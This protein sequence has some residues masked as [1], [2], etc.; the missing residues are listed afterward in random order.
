[1]GSLPVVVLPVTG[2][3][4]RARVRR[5]GGPARGPLAQARVTTALGLAVGARG[6]RP[7]P[8]VAHGPPAIRRGDDPRAVTATVVKRIEHSEVAGE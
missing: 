6:V 7:R 1:M 3:R 8:C 2:E 5:Q 4:G